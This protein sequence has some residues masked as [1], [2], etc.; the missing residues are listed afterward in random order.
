[1]ISRLFSIAGNTFIESLR[2]PV[3]L[4]VLGAVCLLLALNPL[5]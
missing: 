3:F 4:A 5:P 1:M 2:R